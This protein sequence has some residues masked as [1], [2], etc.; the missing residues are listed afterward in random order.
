MPNFKPPPDWNALYAS[1][2]GYHFGEEPSHIARSAL[3]FYRAFDGPA[4][5][6]AL[7]LGCGEGRDTA[8]LAGAGLR[9]DA[10]DLASVGLEK[11]RALLARQGVALERVEMALADVRDFSYPQDFYDLTLAVNIYQFL[12]PGEV[13]AHIAGLQAATKPGGLCAVSVFSP[14]MIEWGA[15]I[16]GH[17]RATADELLAY[18]PRDAGWLPLD[19][20]DHWVYRPD[21]EMMA[22]FSSVIARKPFV[23]STGTVL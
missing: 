5:G 8:F 13:S 10:Y 16:G 21:R 2:K 22:S 11:T 6:L 15:E 9:V 18:F 23:Q 4:D 17:F 12:P 19:R 7:D 1:A 14:A 3:S 20:T